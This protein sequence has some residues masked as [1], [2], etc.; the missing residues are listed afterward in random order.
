MTPSPRPAR[1]LILAGGGLKVAFQAGVLQ[2]WLDEAGLEFDHADGASGGIF[3]LAMY[4]QGMSGTQIA[5]NWRAL[6]VL[7]GVAPNWRKYWKLYFADSLLS[8]SRWRK[9]IHS[10]WALDWD[11]IRN[12]DR[13]ATFNLYNFTTHQLEVWE[14]SEI[15]EDALVSGVSL[16]MWFPPVRIGGHD[17]IDAVYASDANLIEAVRRG[18]DELWIIWTVSEQ[19][20][21]RNGFVANYFQIIEAAANGRFRS[22]LARIEENNAAIEAGEAGEFGR[23]IDIKIL[24]AEVPLHYILN[25][26]SKRFTEAVDLGV[27]MARQWCLRHG[28]E[29]EAGG[30]APSRPQATY[31]EFTEVM[32][33]SV[34]PIEPAGSDGSPIDLAVRLTIQIDDIETFVREPNHAARAVGFV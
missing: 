29:I 24:R 7:R 10:H 21:W 12:S 1:S 16:P 14:A 17:Y 5:D 19:S 15:T 3:N 26:R 8:Y 9:N 20:R 27:Q 25:F 11:A 18:A 23:I 32:K 6:P 31:L 34:T 13:V 28:I 33:G 22:D 4:C 30:T 2:V